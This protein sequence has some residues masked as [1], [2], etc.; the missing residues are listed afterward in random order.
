MNFE[1]LKSDELVGN[2]RLWLCGFG[3]ACAES[4]ALHYFRAKDFFAF[5]FTKLEGL[6]LKRGSSLFIDLI[7]KS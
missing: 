6:R 1:K 3:G 5:A 4:E 2:V 7:F